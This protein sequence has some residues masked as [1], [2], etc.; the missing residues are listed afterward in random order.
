MTTEYNNAASII[1]E[2]GV[3]ATALAFFSDSLMKMIPWLICAVPLI[4]LDLIW[5]VKAAKYRGDKIKLSKGIRRTFGKVMEYICWVVL[6]STLSLAMKFVWVEW[7]VLGIVILN[8]LSSIIGN[9]LE[10]RG[11]EISW[12]YV[13]NKVLKIGGQKV[14]VDVDIDVNEAI[15]PRDP[16]TGR[17]I[18]KQ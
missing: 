7:V 2:G 17:F 6:A 15:K 5:G 1:V 11:L 3:T 4:A 16:K 12:A 14:G 13:W 8:E 18:K 9:Y 10:T